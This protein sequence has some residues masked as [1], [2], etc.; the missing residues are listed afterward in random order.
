LNKKV[1]IQQLLKNL[2]ISKTKKHLLVSQQ[3]LFQRL[4]SDALAAAAAL[5]PSSPAAAAR[6]VVGDTTSRPMMRYHSPTAQASVKD[7]K[8]GQ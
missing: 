4:Y 1:R 2:T 3:S 7:Y 8:K 5:L 6:F